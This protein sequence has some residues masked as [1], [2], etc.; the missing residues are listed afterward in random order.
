M[1]YREE[2]MIL[3][4]GSPQNYSNTNSADYLGNDPFFTKNYDERMIQLDYKQ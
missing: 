4:Q 3:Y 1:L 2:K